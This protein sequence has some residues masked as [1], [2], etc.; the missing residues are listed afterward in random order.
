MQIPYYPM[1]SRIQGRF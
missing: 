1:T